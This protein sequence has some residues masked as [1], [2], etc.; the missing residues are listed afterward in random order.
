M[1]YWLCWFLRL[2]DPTAPRPLALDLDDSD[3][4]DGTDRVPSESPGCPPRRKI[5]SQRRPRFEALEVL[6]D[7]SW[8]SPARP[9][10]DESASERTAPRNAGPRRAFP[11]WRY[12][13]R[14]EGWA[15]PAPQPCAD[16]PTAGS[17]RRAGRV[18]RCVRA[19]GWNPRGGSPATSSELPD[20]IAEAP[21]RPARASFGL[22]DSCLTMRTLSESRDGGGETCA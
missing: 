10:R 3:A 16:R 12:T 18:A 9:K 14:G 20:A 11:E 19:R 15:H 5:R 22:R 21:R 4:R 1:W 2:V 6:P 13:Q 7:A 17:S 8:G